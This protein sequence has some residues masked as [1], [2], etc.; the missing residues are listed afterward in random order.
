MLEVVCDFFFVKEIVTI[1][2]AYTIPGVIEKVT[3]YALANSI[4]V[5]NENNERQLM[6]VRCLAI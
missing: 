1:F 5:L 4:V 3:A 2:V 6:G